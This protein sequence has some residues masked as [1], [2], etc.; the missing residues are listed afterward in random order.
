M[1]L[2]KKDFQLAVNILLKAFPETG[3]HMN[4]VVIK[5]IDNF[6]NC[7]IKLFL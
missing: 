7:I 3:E 2:T 6:S 1:L 4:P 5:N